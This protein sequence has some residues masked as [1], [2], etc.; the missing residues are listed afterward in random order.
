M[1]IKR[2]IEADIKKSLKQNPVTAIIGPRQS[3]KSTIAKKLLKST[4]SIYLDLEK[5]SDLQKLEDPE[6]FFASQK[7]RLICLD[8]IQRKPELFPL[9]RSLSDEWNKNGAFMVLGSASR[10][11]LRQSSESLAG[12]I[13]Y[14]TLYP[15][16]WNEISAKY[17]LEDYMV[18][19]G[20]PRSLLNDDFDNSFEWR[21]D[22]TTTFLERDLLQWAGFSPKTMRNLWQMLAH[23]NGQVVN[24]SSLGRSLDVSNVTVKNYIELLESTFMVKML[25]PFLKN[26]G[27]RI[28]KNPK[29]YLTDPGIT[30]ALLKIR[31]FEQLTGHPVFGYVWES[32]VLLNI[33]THFP[34]VNF[35][36]YRTQNGAELD[37][38][39][40]YG[41]K[42]IA[43]E[44][45]ASKSPSL[46]KGNYYAM[47]DIRPL[48]TLVVA[49]VEKG[50]S[51]K[52][53]IEIV[54]VNEAIS[55]ISQIFQ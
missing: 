46:S 17:S 25:P 4:D 55:Q 40:E 42:T 16:T 15:F 10:D 1:Y 8:E 3:G 48:K 11:L 19:G 2:F 21:V 29:I 38:I 13:S 9:L 7:K 53:N 24:Y 50:W 28:I 47:K 32:L 37:F 49:P 43:I 39:L 27:K 20:F 26:T 52:E 34:Q 51:A 30:N 18:R 12:R 14:K 33:K 54:S 35:S 22:F 31:D 6:W 45:K 36:F 5:P 23:L 41:I 44:C